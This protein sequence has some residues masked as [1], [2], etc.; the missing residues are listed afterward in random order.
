RRLVD[1]LPADTQR[2]LLLGAAEPA[3]DPALL[4]RAAAS[5]GLAAEAATPAESADLLTIGT[6]V[7][8]RHPLLRSAIYNAARPVDR[9]VVHA[10]LADAPDP[11]DDP[12]RRAWHRAHATLAPDE[13]VAA[14]LER[15]AERARTRGG[16]AAAAAFLARAAQLT[17]DPRLRAQR[18]LAAAQRK[19][20]AGLGEDA[21][22]LLATA[23]QGP[24]TDLDRAL[25]LRL[26]GLLDW[27]HGSPDGAAASAPLD[28]AQRLEPLDARLPPQGDLQGVFLPSRPG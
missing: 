25:A 21:T 9:R 17:P 5:L 12:D 7:A 8:F 24:L 26:R 11:D 3:G 15:S 16:L 1:E 18:T 10:A 27:E 28:A 22:T 6:R 2:L 4:W 19:R 13:D 14:E 20:L 23:E